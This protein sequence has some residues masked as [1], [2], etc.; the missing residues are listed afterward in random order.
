MARRDE[1]TGFICAY[2]GQNILALTN[3][4]YR[5][6]CPICLH[7]L[8]VDQKPGDRASKCHGLMRPI[9]LQFRSKKGWQLVHCCVSC[10]AVSVCRI[11]T[12]TV[13]PDDSSALAPLHGIIKRR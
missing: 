9:G 3:G 13:Q 10:A 4:S 8:H 6:H 2:C 7:S 11:A 5:N 12:D 1:N